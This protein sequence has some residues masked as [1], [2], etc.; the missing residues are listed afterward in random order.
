MTASLPDRLRQAADELESLRLAE[1]AAL[2]REAAEML[3]LSA[4]LR[5]EALAAADALCGPDPQD[6]AMTEWEASDAYYL[7]G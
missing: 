2:M 3:E 4:R 6:R 1:D 7:H 5:A